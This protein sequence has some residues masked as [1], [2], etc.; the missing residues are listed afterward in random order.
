MENHI[1]TSRDGVVAAV[2]VAVG[3]VVDTGQLLVSL[4]AAG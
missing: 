3:D 4:G 2:N 1:A